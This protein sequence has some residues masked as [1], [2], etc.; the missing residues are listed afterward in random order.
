MTTRLYSL[1]LCFE[2]NGSMRVVHV[3][4][5]CEGNGS[6]ADQRV[7]QFKATSNPKGP[8]CIFNVK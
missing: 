6:R 4:L 7:S 1:Y 8:N 2:W 3:Y 5:F